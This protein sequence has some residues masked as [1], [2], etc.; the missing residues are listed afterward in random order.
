[1]KTWK[2]LSLG[3]AGLA[4]VALLAAC[5]NSSSGS[6]YPQLSLTTDPTTLDSATNTST[7]SGI[8]IGNTQEGLTRVGKDGK[9]ANA[10]AESI[11]VSDDGLTYSVKL[12]DGLKWSNGDALTAKDFVYSWQRANAPETASQYAYLMANIENAEAIHTGENKDL[13][14]FGVK[15]L[16]DTE[17]EIKL[18]KP[19]PYFEYLL[20]EN[21]Y[22][23]VNKGAVEK[24]GKQYGTASDK[25]V[26]SGPFEFK[27]DAGWTGTNASFKLVKNQNYYDKKNV[28][29]EEIDYQIVKNPNTAVQLF[30]QD[31][32]DQAE[33]STTD[34]Y[35]ANKNY[36]GG[37]NNIDLKEATTAY[38]EYNQ[39]GENTSS[40][41]VAKALKNKKIREAISLATNRK[42]IVDQFVPG[43]TPATGF[44]PVGMAK[45]ATGE[46]FAS[47]A[48]QGYAYD[49]AKAKT[50]W[51]QGLK[52]I[53][54]TSLNISFTTDADKP[55]AKQIADYLQTSLSK[56][57]PG[58][59]L[60]EKI[61]PYAQRLQDSKNGN[62]D[63]VMSVW[64]GDYAE[65]S[66]FLQLF[67]T[68]QSYND[69]KFSSKTYDDAFKAATTTP[70][71]LSQA[72]TD[73]DY[74]LLEDTLYKGSYIN[75]VDFQANPAL[76]NP[77][78]KGLQFHST[79]LAYDLKTA[80]LK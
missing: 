78:I 61:I 58:L 26:Y 9:P 11:K 7:Y 28:K 48:A 37:K 2:K 46:D 25:V 6:Q 18:S 17:L 13:S 21:I 45:N 42:D 72:K 35:T 27:K 50:L 12:R 30:K 4:T 24:Y 75:P 38:I 54:E 14:S 80:Y 66:T 10:L 5:G 20:T 73:A 41:A 60:T 51:E 79:G 32:L 69:G 65:P 53:D 47:Y 29:S 8:L 43:S 39:S 34:L 71:V 1:M 62:F 15:A 40:P 3:T 16:S 56:A 77:N 19:T 22:M 63:M 44:T 59:T 52:E 36:N 33:L 76:M 31:K 64:G 49:T 67:T 57:L 55:S 74:K 23:P 70:D 68:G